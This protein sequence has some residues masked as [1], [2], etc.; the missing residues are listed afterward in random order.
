MHAEQCVNVGAV[1]EGTWP[2]SILDQDPLT[3][4][5]PFLL[6]G[7][8]LPGGGGGERGVR[9]EEGGEIICQGKDS[10]HDLSQ[11]EDLI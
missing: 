6:Q 3:G 11:T 1:R 10:S 5:P 9:G 8:T 2:Q 7:D 4:H